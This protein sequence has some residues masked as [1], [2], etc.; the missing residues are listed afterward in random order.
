MSIGQT[1][2]AGMKAAP[3]EEHFKKCLKN[4]EGKIQ[5]IMIKA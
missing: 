1:A 4:M 5:I 2:Q 3:P